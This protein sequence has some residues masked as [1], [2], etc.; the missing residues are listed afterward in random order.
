MDLDETSPLIN[1]EE[2]HAEGESTTVLGVQPR[3]TVVVEPLLAMLVLVALPSYMVK[4][5]YMYHKI[6]EDLGFDFNNMSGDV[7]FAVLLFMFS[8]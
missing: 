8:R 1:S 3:R 7:Y 4:S 5:L 6:A 2:K